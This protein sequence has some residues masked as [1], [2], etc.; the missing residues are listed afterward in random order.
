MTIKYKKGHL[1]KHPKIDDWGVGVV[2]E[3]GN[4]ETVYVSFKNAGK[5]NHYHFNI[6]NL[7]YLVR[8][9]CQ[10]LK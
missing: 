2:V 8:N 7:K 5:K 6:L 9:P 3:D 10:I 4:N 1:V